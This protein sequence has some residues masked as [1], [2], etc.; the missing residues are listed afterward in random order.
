MIAE[1]LTS[2]LW[3]VAAYGMLLALN[4]GLAALAFRINVGSA[5]WP[6]DDDDF[7][8]RCFVAG[9]SSVRG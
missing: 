3:F 2:T 9:R 6:L 7:W 4:T 5:D 8:W 1:L